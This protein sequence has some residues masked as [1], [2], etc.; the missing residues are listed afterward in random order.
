M[1]PTACPSGIPA[2]QGIKALS[3]RCK[4][5]VV[6][7]RD[8]EAAVGRIDDTFRP[9]VR[10]WSAS[11]EAPSSKTKYQTRIDAEHSWAA[12]DGAS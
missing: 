10:N 9:A 6:G 4:L 1:A 2:G 8:H 3:E 5:R 11:I 7:E 12:E